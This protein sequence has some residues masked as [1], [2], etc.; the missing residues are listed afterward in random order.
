V[1]LGKALYGLG[2]LEEAASYFRRAI[3]LNPA[4]A[5]SRNSLG[6]ALDRGHIEERG[7]GN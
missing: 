5:D 6:V 1:S 2:N 4:D 7:F 3:E